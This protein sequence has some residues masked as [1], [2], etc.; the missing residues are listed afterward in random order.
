MFASSNFFWENLEKTANAC[1]DLR[2]WPDK[3]IGFVSTTGNTF[4]SIVINTTNEK[5][6]YSD[7]S[8]LGSVGINRLTG[9]TNTNQTGVGF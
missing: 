6:T 3:H 7:N 8:S 2:K 4:T 5:L 1:T 9:F